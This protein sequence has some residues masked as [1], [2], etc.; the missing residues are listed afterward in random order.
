MTTAA[1][2]EKL[3]L[4]YV[5]E[6]EKKYA[7]RVYLTQ[8]R[9]GALTLDYTWKDVVGEARRMAAHLATLGLERGDRVGILSKNCAHFFIAE[10]AIWMAGGTTVAI[11][12]TEGRDTIRYVLEHSDSKLLFVGKLDSW[13]QQELGVPEG[14]PHIAFPLAP[15]TRHEQWD[16]IVARTEPL[17][18]RRTRG[19]DELAMIIYTSGS[20]GT[21]KGVMHSFGRVSVCA[22]RICESERYSERDRLIS[23]LP[24]AHVFERS[25]VEAASFV[26]SPH[27]FF[28]ESLETFV[29]DVRR[30]RPTLFISVPRL[31]VKFQQGVLHKMT[32]KKL[33]L[34]LKI[35]ILGSI[36]RKKILDGLGLD[37]VR[38]AGS[39]DVDVQAQEAL[40]VTIAGSGDVRYRGKP[41]QL[42]SQVSGSGTV[43]AAP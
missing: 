32:P 36:V 7:D 12:P 5:F 41:S 28:S 18:G 43:Q 27:V 16:E 6:N 20:T 4:D 11:F 38:L 42:R 31:W 22:E 21:P 8:P 40:T 17:A 2:T 24:L 35:P 33:D 37:Q 9:T 30:A 39:G 14:M 19:A 1:P 25:F 13:G 29:T 26:A 15:A 23:Y 34:F 3:I 10:L